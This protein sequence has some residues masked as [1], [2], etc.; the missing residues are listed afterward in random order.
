MTPQLFSSSGFCMMLI[1]MSLLWLSS[2]HCT[3]VECA[4]PDGREHFEFVDKETGK[5]LVFGPS[6]KFKPSDITIS[7]IVNQET[8][9]AAF[10]DPS[11][12]IFHI[13]ST[14]QF[15]LD[16]GK[17]K[18]FFVKFGDQ[19][20][21]TIDV[22]TGVTKGR[23]CSGIDFYTSFRYNGVSVEKSIDGRRKIVK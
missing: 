10:F 13:D 23:C 19:D 12:P 14:L 7:S 9:A 6:A 21:D 8:I 2:C 5:N 4:E 3:S 15:R 16:I 17:A 11:F 1:T 20:T 22:T 18:Q